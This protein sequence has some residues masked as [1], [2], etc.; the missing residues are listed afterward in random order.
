[1]QKLCIFLDQMLCFENKTSKSR[2]CFYTR[3]L[4]EGNLTSFLWDL[5]WGLKKT[6][7]SEKHCIQELLIQ[8][9]LHPYFFIRL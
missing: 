2:K 9:S 3:I 8:E 6:S 7:Y 1:M 4:N 5:L